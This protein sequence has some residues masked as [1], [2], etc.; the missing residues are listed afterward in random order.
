MSPVQE[1]DL[2]NPTI[3]ARARETYGPAGV[4]RTAQGRGVARDPAATHDETRVHAVSLLSVGTVQGVDVVVRA[5]EGGGLNR[6]EGE[7]QYHS[8]QQE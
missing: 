8:G 1:A 4:H 2:I 5:V 7:R 6:D 3:C